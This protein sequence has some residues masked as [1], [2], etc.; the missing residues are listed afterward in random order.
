V[1]FYEDILDLEG[2]DRSSWAPLELAR[3]LMEVQDRVDPDWVAHSS[4][5]VAFA[6]TYFGQSRPGNTTVLGEQ[7]GD[8]KLWGGTCSKLASVAALWSATQGPAYFR[9]MAQNLL[10][11]MTYFIADSGAPSA[12]LDTRSPQ[13][14]MGW[15]QDS[16]TD[17][18][19]NYVD[20]IA[21]LSG[22][23]GATSMIRL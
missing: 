1:N 22:K 8:H 6:L 18:L 11:Y 7:D 17:V 4:Q 16:L 20:A 21:I 14:L 10:N 19:H 13:P 5:L 3:F 2:T 9:V 12:L 15:Q 23:S